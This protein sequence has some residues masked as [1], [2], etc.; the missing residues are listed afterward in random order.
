[1][2][3][4]KPK[5]IYCL[6]LYVKT[7]PTPFADDQSEVRELKQLPYNHTASQQRNPDFESR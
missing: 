7:L 3:P 5:V 4:T 1:M 2:Q 6:V